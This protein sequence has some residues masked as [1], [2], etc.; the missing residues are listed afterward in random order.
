MV[1]GGGARPR[2]TRHNSR[3]ALAPNVIR[4]RR[5]RT[6]RQ[7]ARSGAR[8]D[9]RGRRAAAALARVGR[10]G[11]APGLP[12]PG[13][14]A[15]DHRTAPVPAGTRA[16]ICHR[17]EQAGVGRGHR[18]AVRGLRPGHRRAAGRLRPDLH[19]ND[20]HRR[21]RL[22]D[23]ALGA[24][25][26]RDGPGHPGGRPLGLRHPRAAPA[27]LAGRGGQPRLPAG[28]PP[29][30]FPD[31]RPAA[32][33]QAGAARRHGRLD[34]LAAARRGARRRV[35]RSGRSG[36]PRRPAGRR[37]RPPAARSVRHDRGRRAASAAHG[38]A[39]PGRRGADL[40]GPGVDPL[41]DG[42]GPVRARRRAGLPG[43][44]P[45]RLGSGGRRRAS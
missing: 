27:H 30:R 39:G 36:H 45:G 4:L 19:R 24:W 37:L 16:R 17:D 15:L 12:G 44:Q 33:G 14:S 1:T 9:H 34:R 20:R 18:G 35:D 2:R 26:G 23:G 10:R 41:D 7:D 11:R 42:A 21:D 31:R 40:P 3:P 28:G 8:G 22:L 25:S 6:L 5:R 43:P 29:G 32:A 38:G 13:H